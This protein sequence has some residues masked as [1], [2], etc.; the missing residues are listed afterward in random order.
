MAW[1]I[2]NSTNLTSVPNIWTN[3][4]PCLDNFPNT[5]AAALA[6]ISLL[7]LPLKGWT[8]WLLVSSP[9]TK[10]TDLIN[11]NLLVHSLLLNLTNLSIMSG[12]ILFRQTSQYMW[13]VLH[14]L[15]AF[16]NPLFQSFIC[17][18][19]YMAVAHPIFFLK[20]RPL[21][22]RVAVLAPAWISLLIMC[23]VSVV[24]CGTKRDLIPKLLTFQ[25]SIQL[26]IFVINSFCCVSILRALTRP[27]PGNGGRER[28]RHGRGGQQNKIETLNHQIKRRAFIIVAVIQVYLVTCYLPPVGVISSYGVLKENHFCVAY[29]VTLWFVLMNSSLFYLRNLKNLAKVR[30]INCL[31]ER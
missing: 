14:C 2:D 13:N 9:I 11:L 16:G 24:L 29:L 5:Y 22:Y 7:G 20:Y 10:K 23:C 27:P 25:C 6:S 17:V 3:C 19:R 21:R 4:V 18:E 26:L 12:I 28:E 15:A 1:V 8:F 30:W 31:K